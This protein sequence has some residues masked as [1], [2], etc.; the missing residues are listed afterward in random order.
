MNVQISSQMGGVVAS[1]LEGTLTVGATWKGVGRY[2]KTHGYARSYK[3]FFAVHLPL[4]LL[5]KAHVIPE[6]WMRNLWMRHLL[7][8]LT[9][10]SDAQVREMAEWVVQ[11]EL[12][13]SRRQTIIAELEQHLA[14]GRRVVITSGTYLPVLEAFAARVKAECIG[15]ALATRQGRLTGELANGINNG[16]R[17]AERLATYLGDS[18]LA[19]AYG[20]TLADVHMLELSAA[21]TAV[22]PDKDLHRAAIAR[23][24]RIVS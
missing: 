20:D 24:W 10:F 5:A 6:Q 8:L 4:V 17:K 1:D 3:T 9:G 13:P 14:E 18:T 19:A 16:E 15:S 7:R 2:L 22:A 11:E 23:G 21:P 12:W